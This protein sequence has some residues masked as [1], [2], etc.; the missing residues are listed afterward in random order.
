MYSVQLVDGR[1]WNRPPSTLLRRHKFLSSIDVDGLCVDTVQTFKETPMVCGYLIGV[2]W[3]K[4]YCIDS[5]D[6]PY[7]TA[8]N[9]SN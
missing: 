8:G 3:R 7:Y 4:Y 6:L 2:I 5:I 9:G 1:D